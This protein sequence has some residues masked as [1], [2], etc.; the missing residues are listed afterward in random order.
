MNTWIAIL[1]TLNLKISLIIL[2]VN[3][4]TSHP[5]HLGVLDDVHYFLRTNRYSESVLASLLQFAD[6][7]LVSG[8]V[9]LEMGE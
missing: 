9:E 3:G 4:Y 5:L 8:K 1:N 6:P 7:G 2:H